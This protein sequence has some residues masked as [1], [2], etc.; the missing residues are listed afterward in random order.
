[1]ANEQTVVLTFRNETDDLE[2]GRQRLRTHLEAV[3]IDVHVIHR[4]EIVVEEM[5]TNIL[6]HGYQGTTGGEVR[7]SVQRGDGCMELIFDDDAVPFDP[8][9]LPVRDSSRSLSEVRPGG[10]GLLLLSKMSNE[11][12]YERIG[13]R[14]RTLIR[15]GIRKS[16]RP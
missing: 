5:I 6:R 9:H 16:D 14:N 4:I 13:R 1:M 3:G 12:C 15:I 11:V 8:G 2:Q 10:L 7:V